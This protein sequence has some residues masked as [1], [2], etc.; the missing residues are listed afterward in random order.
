MQIKHFAGL[1][2]FL[3]SISEIRSTKESH[4][5]FYRLLIETVPNG[6]M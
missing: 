3:V 5:H 2:C 1:M 6:Y 4:L